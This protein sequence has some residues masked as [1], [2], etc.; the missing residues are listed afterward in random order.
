MQTHTAL[1]AGLLILIV[2]LSSVEVVHSTEWIKDKGNPILTP[3]PNG[4][5]SGGV[6]LPRVIY[7]GAKFRMWYL[8]YGEGLVWPGRVGSAVSSN[9]LTWEKYAG[10]VLLPGLQG[11]WDS[12]SVSPGSVIWNGSRL[13]MWYRGLGPGF[14]FGAFGLALSTDGISW[15]KYHGNPVFPNSLR[16]LQILDYPCVLLDR[17]T[18]KMWYTSQI[19]DNGLYMVFYATSDDGIRWTA[20]PSPVLQPEIGAWDS[21]GL[22]NPT[23]ISDGSSYWLWYSTHPGIG[24]ATSKDGISWTKSNNNPILSRGPPGSWDRYSIGNQGVSAF[25]NTVLLYYSAGR[26]LVPTEA[27]SSIGLAR[28]PSNDAVSGISSLALDLL[29]AALVLACIITATLH[30]RRASVSRSR[31]PR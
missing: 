10:P 19:V 11:A 7:D 22:Y 15:T 9:G 21:F 13:M 31:N 24:Y 5:D 25:D 18:Y 29:F 17:G 26:S 30:Y 4:W 8:G 6:Y 23:V 20:R 12:L 1:T 14:E 28:P 2:A 16:S 3:T 27:H